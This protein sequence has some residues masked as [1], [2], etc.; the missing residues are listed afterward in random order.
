MQEHLFELETELSIPPDARP[1]YVLYTDET[2]DNWR[3]QAVPITP[4]SFESR[5]ALPEVWRGLRDDKLSEVSGVGG[6]IFVHASGFIGGKPL[7]TNAERISSHGRQQN[8][9]GCFAARP[10]RAQYVICVGDRIEK[11][12]LGRAETKSHSDS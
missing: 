8:Q 4:E 11:L 1:V 7:R 9:G 10:A 6:G 2:G 12:I 5:K 3:V